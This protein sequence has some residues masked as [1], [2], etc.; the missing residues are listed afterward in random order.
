MSFRIWDTDAP[1]T[2]SVDDMGKT[3]MRYHPEQMSTR[4]YD[5][6][7]NNVKYPLHGA[8]ET[9]L[10][11]KLP[12]VYVDGNQQMSLTPNPRD[13]SNQ[14]CKLETLK[15]SESSNMLWI[16]GQFLDHEIDLTTTNSNEKINIPTP[17]NEHES[18]PNFQI[19]FERSN[20]IEQ[21]PRQFPNEISAFID[22]TNVYGFNT[23]R[24]L[25]LR[26]Y[27]GTGKLKVDTADNGE[28]IL[29]YNTPK[30]KNA[31]LPHQNEQD[32]FLAG[33]IRSNENIFLTAMHTLF[34]REH[35][36]LCDKYKTKY[37]DSDEMIFQHARRMVA[38]YMQ[39]I[40][41]KEFLPALLGETFD[42]H[43][44]Y[45]E[46]IDPS[47]NI[48]FS[49]AGYRLGHSM[50]PHLIPVVGQD[51]LQL[52]DCFF[53]PEFIQQHG[54]DGLLVGSTY[55]QSKKIDHQI[56]DEVRNFLFGSPENGHLLDLAT[57]NIQRGRD[58]GLAKYNQVRQA[59]GLPRL[60]HLYQ[61]TSDVSLQN[62]LMSVYDNIDQVDLW[63]GCICEDVTHGQ[64]GELL[65]HILKDQFTRL[66][67]GDRYWWNNDI[68]L[69]SDEKKDIENITL[70]EIIIRNCQMTPEQKIRLKNEKLF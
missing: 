66:R 1:E 17:S 22:G 60:N 69:S 59:Y 62:K 67:D 9:K 20:Y 49:T 21:N 65:Y 57:L 24:L 29:I 35:N 68:M 36:R 38:A 56:I 8:A 63:V 11:R 61:I 33:D 31:K 51:P 55:G 14:V 15:F 32:M 12:A 5:G 48:E 45:D 34:V 6:N 37:P 54:V 39:V 4:N 16:W 19:E 25:H 27:D 41:Y 52:R 13:I 28:Q 2:I 53:R 18:Y 10:L 40:T 70:G 42:V 50:L 26:T 43:S 46:E 23:S 30:L 3:Y 44:N 64:V 58:H 7:A 47:V